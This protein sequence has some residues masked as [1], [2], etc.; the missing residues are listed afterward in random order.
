MEATDTRVGKT[1]KNQVCKFKTYPSSTFFELLTNMC[2]LII[3][4]FT[5]LILLRDSILLKFLI[6]YV[7]P[8]TPFFLKNEGGQMPT[9]P[10]QL[11]GPL[12]S[13]FI[14]SMNAEVAFD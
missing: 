13:V 4:T 5:I 7:G 8:F 3:Y 14:L 1:F 2:L 9:S 12:Q 11:L 10:I 6:T